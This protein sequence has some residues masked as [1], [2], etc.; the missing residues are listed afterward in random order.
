M[1]DLRFDGRVA[2]VTGAGAGLGRAYALL[3]ASRGAKVVVNDLG[4]SR[5]GDGSSSNAADK[6]VEEIRRNGGTAVA[7]YDS[8]VEGEKVIKTALDNFGKVDILINNAGILRDKS[9]V[10]MTDQDW[11]LIHQVHVKGSFKTSQAAFP[12]FK[13]QG[14]GRIIMTSSVAG[15]YGNFGQANY[16]AAKM[17]LVGLSHTVAKE[18]AKYNIHCNVIVPTAG[19]RLTEDILPPDLF[20]ELRPELI[21]PVVVRYLFLNAFVLS[22]LDYSSEVKCQG[23]LS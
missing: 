7:N 6:V 12:I 22:I 4:V 8:V 5:H 13:K 9:L 15:L 16:S 20:A 10:K 14:Y 11:D 17:G 23:M 3:F 19:S 21:A 18:G 2:V 1:P